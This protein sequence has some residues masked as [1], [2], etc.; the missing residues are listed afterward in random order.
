MT[1]ATKLPGKVIAVIPARGGS[2]S[3]PRK[4]LASVGGVP[5]VARSILAAKGASAVDEVIVSSDD[6]EI[7]AVA[8]AYGATALQRPAAIATDEATSESALLH[9]LESI[10]A[11]GEPVAILVFLQCTS[12]FTEAAHVDALI[13]AV[14]G[15]AA[16][17]LTVSPNHYFL[18]REGADGLGHG[19]N[20]DDTKQRL[21]RQDLPPEYRE[22]GAGYAMNA[23]AF[24]AARV[25]FC[26]PTAL[27]KTDLPA[28]E[29]DDPSDLIVINA[30]FAAETAPPP[31][32]TLSAIRALVTDFDG[33]HTDD[34][35]YVGDD[36]R[37]LVRCS[38]ADGM[39]VEMLKASGIE[40]LILSKET[41]VVVARR[42]E[43]LKA[44]VMHGIGE[45]RAVLETWAS[46]NGFA[47]ADIAYIGNDVNDVSC[48]RAVG[49]ALAPADAHP[50]AKAAAHMVLAYPGGRGAVRAACDMLIAAR[51][52][53]A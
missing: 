13:A 48:M 32:P 37:E 30:M 45:K 23:S 1:A 9:A 35:V 19:V 52:P 49:L 10:E 34:L 38:R 4:N 6:A 43:K 26:G 11:R 29:I 40:F 51:K 25:R 14:R 28:I 18:W 33:V 15:G 22:N 42:A 47:L 20:H 2:K 3:I 27:V 12:P 16:A 50:S 7:L 31:I 41:N 46:E 24:K 17:A 53:R 36:G 5:L 39:G 44:P 8:E 21:R